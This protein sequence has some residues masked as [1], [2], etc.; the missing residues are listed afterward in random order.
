MKPTLAFLGLGAMGSRMAAR[1]LE[2]GYELSLYNRSSARAN[3]PALARARLAPT[4]RE[5]AAGRDVVIAMLRDD[6]ASRSVWLDGTTG[7][8]AGMSEG[9]LAIE[10]STLTLAY[11]EHW[12]HTLSK[13]GIAC[14]DAPVSGSRP[15]AQAGKLIYL[16]GGETEALERVRDVLSV[17]GDTVHHLGPAASGMVMKLAVNALL[18][19]QTAA[20][21]EVLGL[22]ER[23][24]LSPST[25]ADLLISLPI[26]SPAAKVQ[27]GLMASRSFDP[28]FPI[29]L[30][31]KDLGCVEAAAEQLGAD[32]PASA[33]AH[34][35][36]ARA[37]ELGLGAENIAAVCKL[38]EDKP[39]RGRSN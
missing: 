34:E 14:L 37:L 19:V 33:R 20:L 38:F 1:L 5:A 32:V 2:A 31:D 36:F 25:V 23:A 28:M 27:L 17:M 39:T 3:T 21:G 7:A 9:A 4:P 35:V 10:S 18:A 24:G 26:T 15:Q 30:V 11:V 29:E 12:H 13:R 6:D 22:T 16:V 8:V